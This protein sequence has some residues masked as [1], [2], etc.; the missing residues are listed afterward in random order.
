[1]LS[2]FRVVSYG[3]ALPDGYLDAVQLAVTGAGGTAE[4]PERSANGR[5]EVAVLPVAYDGAAEAGLSGLRDAVAALAARFGDEVGTAVVPAALAGPER[6]LLIMDVDS[7][8]IQQEVIELLA[9][10]AGQLA[11]VTAVTEAAMRGEL[12]FAQSL[13]DRV[14]TLEQLPAEVIDK[15]RGAVE[16][17]DGAAELVEAFLSK[18]HAVAVVSGGFAQILDP[19]AEGLQLTY[20]RAN[21]LGV[22]D[23]RLT[24]TVVGAVVDR[25]V[26]EASLREW[27]AAEGIDLA[28]T[29]AIGD[30]AN[31]L[32]MLAAA[33][34]GVAFN[35]KPAVREAADAAITIGYLDVAR[36]FA[37]V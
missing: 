23:G 16:L 10:H 1:M 11:E 6:K 4:A 15:V 13:H 36:Y 14:A 3:C 5:F 20:W 18:G 25:A 22:E 35:A 32:D 33:G 37:G 34:L 29:I 21:L 26:K 27:A 30:G 17:T 28:H 8:L 24:G 12:D 2:H 19:L 7:T 9:E 31:D